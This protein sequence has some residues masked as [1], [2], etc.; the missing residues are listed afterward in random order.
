MLGVTKTLLS[1]GNITN[2]GCRVVFS[3]RQSL[4]INSKD[5]TKVVVI[6]NIDDGNGL[7]KFQLQPYIIPFIEKESPTTLKI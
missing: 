4:I 3:G 1:V 5:P 6:G 7:Y 2:K